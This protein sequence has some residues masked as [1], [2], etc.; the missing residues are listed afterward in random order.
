MTLQHVTL[1]LSRDQEADCVAFYEL[2][3]FYR[4]EPPP[5]LADRAAW[6]QAGEVQV[7]LMWV[8]EPTALPSGHIAVVAEGYDRTLE[9]LRA[10]GHEVEP[11]SEHWG[12]PRS[13]VRDPAGNLV[14]VMAFPP[15]SG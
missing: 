11:R 14:E 12:S 8:E 4:V 1:E 7:H 6:M 13:Y 3:G 2:L 10:A 5:S 9:A 15:P